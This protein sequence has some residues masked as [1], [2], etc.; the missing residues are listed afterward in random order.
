[1]VLFDRETLLHGAK[2]FERIATTPTHPE[3]GAPCDSPTRGRRETRESARTCV[4]K[5][6]P[7]EVL[8]RKL[9]FREE[10]GRF[11]KILDTCWHVP[12]GEGIQDNPL[13][14]HT[15]GHLSNG[16]GPCRAELFQRVGRST[17]LP[18]LPCSEGRVRGQGETGR[19]RSE[20]RVTQPADGA[21]CHLV[22]GWAQASELDACAWVVA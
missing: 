2:K 20:W 19:R 3:S 18:Q 1:M 16:R 13:A 17:D 15:V 12:T 5:Q 4:V 11:D 9:Q 14:D 7:H 8:E 10:W 6:L 22:V 21:S